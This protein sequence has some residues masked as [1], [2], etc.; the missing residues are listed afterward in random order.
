MIENFSIQGSPSIYSDGFGYFYDNLY[1]LYFTEY[2]KMCS[3]YSYRNKDKNETAPD[4]DKICS[5]IEKK[6]PK[7]KKYTQ[8]APYPNTL[9]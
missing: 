8:Y 4:I 2:N 1:R 7:N 6:F 5:F 3:L 9:Y